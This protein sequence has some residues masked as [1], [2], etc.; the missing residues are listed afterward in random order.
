MKGVCMPK[1]SINL[2]EVE[3]LLDN[4]LLETHTIYITES[5]EIADVI[6]E[7][8]KNQE[9]Q[10]NCALVYAGMSAQP[11]NG[12]QHCILT[13]DDVE[14]VL[15]LITNILVDGTTNNE[16]NIT[17]NICDDHS[18][19]KAFAV[20]YCILASLLQNT[21]EA[22]ATLVS[23]YPEVR[24]EAYWIVCVFDQCLQAKDR[25]VH[26]F[27]EYF[28]TRILIDKHGRTLKGTWD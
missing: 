28:V 15:S 12:S 5:S 6:K 2:F 1:I 9:T 7:A 25:L 4:H 21:N 16:E 3:D 10:Y 24:P 19:E 18:K 14:V 22:L 23:S 20:G 11:M 26:T 17:I 27:D 13:D 8:H